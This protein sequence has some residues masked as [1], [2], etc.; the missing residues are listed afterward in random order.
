MR[1]WPNLRAE[2]FRAEHPRHGSGGQGYGYFEI[3]SRSGGKLDRLRV[4]FS[5]GEG[6]WEHA[7]ISLATRPPTWAEMQVVKELFWRDDEWVVSYH[8][9]REAFVENH[10]N[11]LHLWRPIDVEMPT[12]PGW[13]VGIKD[14]N[15]A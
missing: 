13:M 6:G 4:I 2:K 10:P 9:A 7:S 12:P 15:I 1:N 14:L 5:G 3:P 8:P 11:C